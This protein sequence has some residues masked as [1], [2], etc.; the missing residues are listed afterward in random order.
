MYA[1]PYD[2]RRRSMVR[3]ANP[4]LGLD[5]GAGEKLHGG[6]GC[7]RWTDCRAHPCGARPNER[8]VACVVDPGT[9]VKGVFSRD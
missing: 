2:P 6:P 3:G 4:E 5:P 8:D 1:V 9:R 7:T